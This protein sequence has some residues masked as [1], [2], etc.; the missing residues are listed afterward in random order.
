M[1]TE[2]KR[3]LEMLQQGQVTVDQAAALLNAV[4][5]SHQ[6]ES[7][8]GPE[9]SQPQAR[10]PRPQDVDWSE[11]GR[12]LAEKVQSRVEA[13]RRGVN[14]LAHCAFDLVEVV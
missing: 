11:F 13:G 2:R 4:E 14:L 3:I 9:A 12:S 10:R 6:T 1:E 5:Q 7:Q 8:A